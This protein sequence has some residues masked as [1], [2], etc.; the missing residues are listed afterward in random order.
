MRQRHPLPRALRG[1]CGTGAGVSAGV[2]RSWAGCRVLSV[3]GGW[4]SVL[5][6]LEA[7]RVHTRGVTCR[8]GEGWLRRQSAAHICPI[9]VHHTEPRCPS[10]ACHCCHH[11]GAD[12]DGSQPRQYKVH[13]LA[14]LIQPALLPDGQVRPRGGF[15]VGCGR[16]DRAWCTRHAGAVYSTHR[17]G[18]AGCSWAVPAC[19]LRL[20]CGL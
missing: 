2:G 18:A 6:G 19:K 12:L 11:T 17:R 9:A 4:C 10:P 13:T 14:G 20:V 7:A 16:Q 8:C 5:G 1:R 15:A 3:W